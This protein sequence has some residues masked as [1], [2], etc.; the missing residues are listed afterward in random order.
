MKDVTVYT[1][2]LCPYCTRVKALLDARGVAYREIDLGRNP[3]GRAELSRKT[4]MMTFPQVLIDGQPL[5][6]FQETAEAD[7]S[8]RLRELLEPAA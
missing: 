1:T 2:P 3:E 4:G 8:G 6:G 5:G 7:R